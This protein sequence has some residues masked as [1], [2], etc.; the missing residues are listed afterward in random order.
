MVARAVNRETSGRFASF[1]APVGGW[2]TRDPLP[3]MPQPD[4]PVFTNL[5][6]DIEGVKLRSGY[7]QFATTGGTYVDF[8]QPFNTVYGPRFI[9]ASNKTLYDI[10]TGTAS[11]IRSGFLRDDWNARVM[12]GRFGMVNGGD[13]PIELGFSPASGATISP[14]T[15]SGLHNPARLRIIHIHKS[16]SY[17]A[18]GKEP[19]FYYSA[20]NALGGTLTKFPIDRVSSTG[21]NVID[22]KSWTVDAGDGP[23]DYFVI[24]LDTGEVLVYT[25]SDPGDDFALAGRYK[26]GRIITAEQFAGQIHAVTDFDYN[27]FPRDFATHG[28]RPPSKLSGA[29]KASVRAKG[30]LARWQI[31][32][33]PHLGLRIINVPQS[34]STYHQHVLNLNNGAPALFTDLNA[35]RWSVFKN[36]L[37]FGDVDGNVNRYTGTSDDGSA[38]SWRMATAPNRLGSQQEKAVLEYR[39]VVSGEGSL[40]EATGLAYDYQNPEFIQEHTTDTAGTPWDTSPWDTSEWSSSPKTKGDWLSGSGQGQAVQLYS[41]GS[42]KG[43][44]PVWHSIDYIYEMADPH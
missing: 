4:A 15:I 38:I 12:N 9:A 32:F 16:R 18:T 36:E 23:D 20:V 8:L 17:F 41:R 11:S 29:A 40:T 30:G 13:D 33:V 3:Q 22:L 7:T 6:S 43:F 24:F 14:L 28:I 39:T 26:V 10:T 37:Y 21:G 31:V 34:V 44:T 2:N 27:I 42:V 1:A 19:A 5:L 35:T 25:G